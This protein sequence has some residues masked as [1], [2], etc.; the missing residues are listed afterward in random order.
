[1]SK[2]VETR[3]INLISQCISIVHNHATMNNNQN[4]TPKQ[5]APLRRSTRKKPSKSKKS[6][7]ETT[8]TNKRRRMSTKK[9]T[10]MEVVFEDMATCIDEGKTEELDNMVKKHC[11]LNSPINP[12]HS[13]T[14]PELKLISLEC[15]DEPS[16]FFNLQKYLYSK[17]SILV[18]G[19]RGLFAGKSFQKGDRIGVYCGVKVDESVDPSKYRLLD[20]EPRAPHKQEMLCHYVNDISLS[21]TV[22]LRKYAKRIGSNHKK[23]QCKKRFTNNAMFHGKLLEATRPIKRN[24]EILVSY[25]YEQEV[26]RAEQ[27]KIL[28]GSRD[29]IQ[30]LVQD[31]SDC[32]YELLE[33][34]EFLGVEEED[35]QSKRKKTL[36]EM[37]MKK[38]DVVE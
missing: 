35:Y 2:P 18:P 3:Y 14:A 9:Y 38:L 37:I 13:L 1:M 26:K 31:S 12:P 16:S 25:N 36:C 11:I 29:L 22:H 4:N 17:E 28:R 21:F 10:K 7:T 15:Y 23:E 6:S 5:D 27:K 32:K 34:Y 19:E 20:I 33:I 30:S 8:E 24:E